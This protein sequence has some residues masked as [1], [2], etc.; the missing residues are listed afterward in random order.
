MN[1]LIFYGLITLLLLGAEVSYLRLARRLKIMD[2]PN[3][4][5]A[6]GQPTVRG[7]GIVFVVA[8]GLAEAVLGWPHPYFLTGLMLVAGISFW[9][10]WRSLPNRYRVAV[11][12]GAVALLGRETGVW[13]EAAW[14]YA[15]WLIVGVGI[16]N[17]GNFMD[18]ING[19]TAFYGLVTTATLGV[20][21]G[22]TG[23]AEAVGLYSFVGISLLIFSYFNARP[24]AVCFSGDVGSVSL[25]FLMLYG[26]ARLIVRE[27]TYLPLLLLAVYGTDTI[28]TIGHRFYLRQNIFRAHRL[29]LF[30]WLVHRTGWP[31]LRVS[32]LYAG[33]QF[34]INLL[35]MKTL[36]WQTDKQWLL[37][38]TIL[39]TLT[40]GYVA[41]KRRLVM[42]QS[43]V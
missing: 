31:H 38:G 9:D 23:D 22:Q 1:T 28:L 7:G 18:G 8:A 2:Q 6:H 14:L 39:L 17:A 43:A 26:V 37:A 10:D 34:G 40:V 21:Y 41:V 12:F 24:R 11:Q 15:G 35:I 16:L 25:A 13:P 20:W 30:Q 36:R 29:H 5:S 3:E 32:A 27:Q 4:R 33:I 42:N 19:M